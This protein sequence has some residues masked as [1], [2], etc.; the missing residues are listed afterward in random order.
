MRLSYPQIIIIMFP[1]FAP[2]CAN[3]VHLWAH[4]SLTDKH[5]CLILLLVVVLVVVLVVAVLVVAVV[6]VIVVLFLLLLLLLLL[7]MYNS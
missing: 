1:S 5:F 2:P 6:V 4:C 3:N 7:L